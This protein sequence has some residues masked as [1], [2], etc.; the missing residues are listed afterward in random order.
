MSKKPIFY[1][2]AA[3][4]AL[5]VL[6]TFLYPQWMVAPG[7]PI[8]AHAALETDCFACHTPFIGSR[9]AK[10]VQCHQPAEI[11][12]VTT[13]GLA[14]A[15][16]RKL[17]PFHQDLIEQDCV[18]C[19]SDHKGVQAFRPI[20]QFSHELLQV[21]TRDQC[22]GCHRN[23][24]DSLH[25]EMVAQCSEC[26]SSQSWLPATLDH[27]QFFRFDQDHQTACGTCHMDQDYSRYTC[28]GC[29]EHSR[30]NIRE[31]HVKEGIFNYENCV[32][33]HRSGEAEEGEQGRAG[34]N[35]GRELEGLAPSRMR[36]DR[37]EEQSRDRHGEHGDGDDD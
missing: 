5:L 19:H 17:V 36:Q 14:I 13:K 3:N 18:A 8:E 6:I 9:P 23:P 32:E 12:L 33:C 15:N 11:G 20:G 21:K 16:E 37:G 1:I 4:L 29:H 27:D 28:Y 35:T 34:D 25:R 30:S 31:E 7:P 26:H 2:V 22:N 24:G 10:C